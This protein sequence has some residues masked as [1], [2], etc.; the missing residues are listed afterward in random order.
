[1]ILINPISPVALDIF[2][3]QIRWYALAYIAAFVVGFWIVRKLGLGSGL[4]L[5]AAR[6][7]AAT[8]QQV[9]PSPSPDP[10][11]NKKYYDDLFAA[12]ILGVIIGGRLG[13]VLFYNLPFFLHYPWEIPMVWHGGMSFHGGLIG[14]IVAV[15]LFARKQQKLAMSNEQCAMGSRGRSLL[16]AHCS[17][18]ILDTLAVAAPI[19]LFFGRIANFINMEVMGRATTRAWGVVFAGAADQTPRHPSPLYEAGLEG[20]LLFIIMLCLWRTKLRER[21]GA[22]A[23]AAMI[24]Y[25]VFRIFCEQFREP[26]AQLGFLFGTDWITM[27]ALLSVAMIVVGMVLL[28][29]KK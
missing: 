13:Y 10:S 19:G 15:S 4:G 5:G 1:M 3:F 26:D 25:A 6:D 23:G 24:L 2:G 18:H 29:R 14:V 7:N 8:R 17:L 11:P 27:G 16:I 21:P 28:F 20:I 12:L 9:T 22:L